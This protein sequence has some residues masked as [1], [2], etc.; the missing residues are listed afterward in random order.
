[1]RIRIAVVSLWAEDVTAASH[2]YQEVIGLPLQ[3]HPA[4][5]HPH[6]VL[7]DS[8]L[9]IKQGR[10]V[11]PQNPEPRFPV[12]AFSVPDLDEA[13]ARLRSH[14]V[15]LPWGVETNTS[16]R[17]VMFRDP[18]GNL[19]ELVEFLVKTGDGL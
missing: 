3:T 16:G 1:L 6:F 7:G 10:P 12:V 17:W 2:F 13:L 5:D 9:T 11:L 4:R 15:E 18:A 19:I 8:T 14:G